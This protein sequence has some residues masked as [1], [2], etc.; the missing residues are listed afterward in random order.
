MRTEYPPGEVC[1]R[2]ESPF[3]KVTSKSLRV[4]SRVKDGLE[5]PGAESKASS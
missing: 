2:G 3:S 1:N 5:T 4:T